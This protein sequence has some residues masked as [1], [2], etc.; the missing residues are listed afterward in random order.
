MFAPYASTQGV[1]SVTTTLVQREHNAVQLIYRTINASCPTGPKYAK[2]QKRVKCD[3]QRRWGH[4]ECNPSCEL[5]LGRSQRHEWTRA[6]PPGNPT[7]K[8]T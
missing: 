8:Y 5:A 7:A 4:R 1:Q 2:R 6:S 3:R